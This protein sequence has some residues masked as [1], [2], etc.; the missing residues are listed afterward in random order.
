M[1]SIE[2]T[3]TVTISSAAI[4]SSASLSLCCTSSDSALFGISESWAA[5]LVN[6][7]GDS[8]LLDV[9]DSLNNSDVAD[10]FEKERFSTGNS[11]G[12]CALLRSSGSFGASAE[13]LELYRL[14]IFKRVLKMGSTLFDGSSEELLLRDEILDELGLLIFCSLHTVVKEPNKH[15]NKK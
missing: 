10:V 12:L 14:S 2:Q 8:V 9:V 6:D 1:S 3:L 7:C 15:N 11:R 5:D 4:F 13:L